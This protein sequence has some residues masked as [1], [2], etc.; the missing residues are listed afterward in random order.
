VRP[1]KGESSGDDSDFIKRD[2]KFQFPRSNCPDFNGDNPIEWV[3]KCNC[4]FFMHQVSHIH[5]THLTT[6]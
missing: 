5:K 6:I 1:K 3:R 2:I 4:Y